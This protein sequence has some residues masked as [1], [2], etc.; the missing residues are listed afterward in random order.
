MEVVLEALAIS[1]TVANANAVVEEE[2]IREEIIVMMIIVVVTG[3][4]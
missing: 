1:E 4:L 3:H 2:D